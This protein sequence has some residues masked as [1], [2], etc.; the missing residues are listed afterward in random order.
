MLENIVPPDR[1]TRCR[2]RTILKDL[3][4]LDQDRLNTFLAN[5]QIWSALALSRAM[6][7]VN[8]SLSVNSII[9]HRRGDCSC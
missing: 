5:E 7:S 2:V 8:V 9:K 1:R 3:D 6:T 4:E